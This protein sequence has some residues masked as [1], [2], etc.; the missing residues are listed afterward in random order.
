[1]LEVVRLWR[2]QGNFELGEISFCV[3]DGE[4]YAILGPSGAGKTTL[5]DCIAGFR[6]PH[7][8]KILLD[9]VDITWL[10]PERRNIAYIPQT[11]SLFPHM[12]VADN[13]AYGLRVRGF[14][15][16]ETRKA[17]RELAL[18]LGIEG[19]LKRYP[20]EISGGEMQ[21]VALARALIVRPKLLLM[22]EPLTHLDVPLRRELRMEIRRII[23]RWGVA[24]IYV[25]HDQAE[26]FTIADR[27]AIMRSGKIVEE[28]TPMSLLLGPRS[29]F[30]AQFLGFE[31]VFRG[32]AT[33]LGEHTSLVDVNGVGFVV[34]GRHSGDICI[35][36]RPED[37]SIFLD[38]PK[39][40]I[41]NIFRGK[42]AE[43][44]VEGPIA[45]I[46]IDVGIRIVA[47][48]T[49]ASMR[50]LGLGGG[51]EVYVGIKSTSIRV[52]RDDYE[53]G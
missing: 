17:V 35:G 36:F 38:R 34:L 32:K 7:S 44:V 31:N 6:M 22:D 19:I 10:P 21:R 48:I 9:G 47:A 29:I 41:R 52:L 51:S 50:E 18:S 25:T 43:I 2:R 45:R 53:V 49:T 30:S 37:V 3:Q 23:K 4:I 24:T 20:G 40:S 39:S 42:I 13:I 46:L 8:G 11:P 12:T 33:C 15:R 28:G 26:A 27:M 14:G 5:L 16:E 1:M